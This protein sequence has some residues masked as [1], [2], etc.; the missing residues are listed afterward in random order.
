MFNT[1]VCRYI[2]LNDLPE[3]IQAM[4]A[5]TINKKPKRSASAFFINDR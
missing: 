2:N 5:I 4:V 3:D 1:D